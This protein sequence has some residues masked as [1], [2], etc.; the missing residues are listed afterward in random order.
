MYAIIEFGG[1]QWKVEPG[2]RLT[3]NRI[4]T[5][6]GDQ[7]T[8]DRVLLAHDGESVRIGRPYV[9]GAHVV[10]EVLEHG[11]GAKVVT[12]KFRRRENWRRTRGHRQPQTR[13]LVKDIALGKPT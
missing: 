7:H 2:T 10:C 13:V 3:I 11:R 12:Y 5:A 9:K 4:P 1:R 8:V 6:V